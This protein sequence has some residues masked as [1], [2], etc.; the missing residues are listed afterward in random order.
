MMNAWVEAL[1]NINL[2]LEIN[3]I[4]F[5]LFP[6]YLCSYAELTGCLTTT[7]RPCEHIILNRVKFMRILAIETSC[8]ETA[9]ALY[10]SEAGLMGH[11]L[12][13]QIDL[14]AQYGGVVPELAS[15]DHV[16]KLSI[17]TSN[18]CS[19]HDMNL[20]QLE[21][22]VYTKG[23]GL[24]GAL[25]TGAAFAQGLAFSIGC[26][27]LGVHHMEGHLLAAMLE[28][29][30]PTYPFLALLVSGGHTLLVAVEAFGSYHVLG[31]SIDDAVG[32]AFDKTAKIMGLPYPGGPYIAKM[33]ASGNPQCF[34]FPRP[35]TDRAGFDFSFSGLKTKALLTIQAHTPN[36]YPD[37]AA[38]FQ[39]AIIDTLLIKC[40]QAIQHTGLTQLVIAGGVGANQQL[41]QQMATH[42]IPRGVEVFYPR[43]EFCTDNAA[44]IAYV[45]SLRLQQGQRNINASLKARW[46]LNSV[47]DDYE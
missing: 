2:P 44:M 24:I 40:Q 7:P 32:E 38:S 45:G 10:D 43:P 36:D 8:D 15:R 13:S 31:E 46:P 21:G 16:K 47:N 19:K 22:I 1:F 17:L 27:L 42:F 3:T 25:M 39:A 14:H 5:T 41:R 20:R 34:T 26:P 35:M 37:I 4:R 33:A 28:D 29:P 9:V 12:Y 6:S 18:L 30:A 11:D 23:P